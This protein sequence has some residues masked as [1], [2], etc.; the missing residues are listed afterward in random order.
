MKP[1]TFSMKIFVRGVF[2]CTTTTKTTQ[3]RAQ[4]EN[5]RYVFSKSRR[6]L[7]ITQQPQQRTGRYTTTKQTTLTVLGDPSACKHCHC[8]FTLGSTTDSVRQS[9]SRKPIAYPSHDY[10]NQTRNRQNR[11]ERFE[12]RGHRAQPAS[13]QRHVRGRVKNEQAYGKKSPI[14]CTSSFCLLFHVSID[15]LLCSAPLPRWSLPGLA[16]LV[17]D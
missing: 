3:T 14:S 5:E 12:R 8:P 16:A 1:D 10:H 13:A 9:P 17:A 6:I 15:I 2:L 11:D 4:T 7:L